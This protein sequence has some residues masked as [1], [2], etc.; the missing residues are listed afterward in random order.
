MIIETI[1]I[2]LYTFNILINLDIHINN[3]DD[4]L[5]FI[6]IPQFTKL[7]MF[8]V[9][10][11]YYIYYILF[12]IFSWLIMPFIELIKYTFCLDEITFNICWYWK[13]IMYSLSSS[14]FAF[15]CLFWVVELFLLHL[16][17]NLTTFFFIYYSYISINFW[18]HSYNLIMP[19]I[20]Y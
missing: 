20:Y 5:I 15:L 17:V 4:L 16:N 3:M 10:Y 12:T 19:F 1:T 11:D 7:Y 6:F 14:Q 13:Y 2:I 18:Y 9:Y 8:F